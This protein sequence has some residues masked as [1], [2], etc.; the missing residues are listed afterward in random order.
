MLTRLDELEAA[1]LSFG[2][3]TTLASIGFVRRMARLRRKGYRVHITFLSLPSPGMAIDRVAH[4][5]QA[6]GHDVPEADIRRRFAAGL[7]NLFARYQAVT[8]DWQLFDNSTPSGPRLIAAG[9]QHGVAQ[10]VDAE[11]WQRLKERLT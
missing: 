10:V 3:E 8:D 11:A 7:R 4:R 2:F 5:V 1:R 6:G 9:T